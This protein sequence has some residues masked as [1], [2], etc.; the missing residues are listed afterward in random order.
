MSQLLTMKELLDRV[1]AAVA[2]LEVEDGRVAPILTER[3]VRYYLTLGIVRP[4]VRD[5]GRS[6]WTNE[7][8]NDLIR[9]RRAQSRGLPLK[10]LPRLREPVFVSRFESMNVPA[11]LRPGRPVTAPDSGWS[12]RISDDIVLTG[13]TARTPDSAQLEAIRT[14]LAPLL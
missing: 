12:M 6:L 14:V 3:T 10:N 9:I 2:D 13:F 4:P 7:H 5:G 8:V 11:D 1:R